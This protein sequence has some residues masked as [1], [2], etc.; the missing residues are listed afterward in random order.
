MS[1]ADTDFDWDMLMRF[2]LGV[3]GL[4]PAAFWA[5]TPREFDA[6]VKGRLGIFE[7]AGPFSRSRFDALSARFPD[8]MRKNHGE[9]G[10]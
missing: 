7:S 8:Q 1:R 4:G 5:M 9:S 2:G 6:A 10:N 3:L